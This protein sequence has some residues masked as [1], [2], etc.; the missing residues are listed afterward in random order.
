MTDQSQGKTVAEILAKPWIS[1][2][3]YRTL[4][5]AKND[6]NTTL[7]SLRALNAIYPNL[8]CQAGPKK[9]FKISTAKIFEICPALN[10]ALTHLHS[11]EYQELRSELD[12]LKKQLERFNI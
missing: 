7:S 1:V 4:T 11:K 3:E 5:G 9:K 8:I 2:T 6:R 10:S 12:D